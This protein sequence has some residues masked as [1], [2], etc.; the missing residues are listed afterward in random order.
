MTSGQ[1]A[2]SSIRWSKALVHGNQKHKLNSSL[3]SYNLKLKGFCR[4][5]SVTSLRNFWWKL[6]KKSHL[7]EWT[8]DSFWLSIL[9]RLHFLKRNDCSARLRTRLA[10]IK[11]Q[12]PHKSNKF[13]ANLARLTDITHNYWHQKPT[14]KALRIWSSNSPLK[15]KK[16]EAFP[17]KIYSNRILML[18]KVNK[19]LK[20][21]SLN[22]F[23]SQ[24][25]N[26]M[27]YR[28]WNIKNLNK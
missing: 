17:L 18:I 6:F 1:S 19:Y 9:I 16:I 23:L 12:C 15:Y 25:N 14:K 13:P 8:C 3:S 22:H 10:Q 28:L 20:R 7:K 21:W 2:S 5:I 26:K 4:K 24:K 11:A 27:N